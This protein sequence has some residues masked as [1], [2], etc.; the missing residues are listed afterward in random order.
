MPASNH[1][2]PAAPAQN[3]APPQ[4]PKTLAAVDLGSNSFHLIVARLQGGEWSVIDR[5]RETVRLGAG[6]DNRKRLSRGARNR[7]LDCLERFGQRLRHMPV[8]SVRVVGTNTLRQARKIGDFVS[9]AEARLGHPIEIVAGREEA[10]LI[11]LGVAHGLE[12]GHERRLVMDIGG[13]STELVA[14]TGF[15]AGERESLH[16]GCVSWSREFFPDGQLKRK[17]V[18]RAILEAGLLI[19]PVAEQFRRAGWD[20]VIGCSGTVRAVRS[21]VHAQGWCQQGITRKAMDSLVEQLVETGN[22]QDLRLATLDDDRRPVFAGG[23]AIL[24]ALFETLD[25]RQMDVS[26]EAMREGLLYDL[27]GRITHSDVRERTVQ[28][29]AE[30]WS[31]DQEHASRVR[32]TAIGLLAQV[33]DSWQLKHNDYELMLGWGATLHEIGLSISHGSYHKHG[34]YVLRNADLSG[35]SRQEQVVLAVLVRGHRRRFPAQDF[36]ALSTTG[37]TSAARL[38]VLLRIA[39]LLHRMRGTDPAPR[40]RV[41]ARDGSLSLS[42]DAGWLAEHAMTRADLAHERDYLAAAGFRLRFS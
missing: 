42:F 11:Y 32:T 6:L 20:R 34:A 8:G 14:G 10:R 28:S 17:R 12:A 26:D 30:R 36:D 29:L 37:R 40:L 4:A 38:T 5:L 18:R 3:P 15:D 2:P 1:S 33:V 39:V 23:V 41:R 25:I 16:L 9:A 24:A 31:L 27:I 35:F 19:Q 7:A 13:G 22:I 21:V